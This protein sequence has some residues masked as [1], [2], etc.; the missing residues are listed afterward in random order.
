VEH[1]SPELVKSVG[2]LPVV[3]ICLLIIFGQFIAMVMFLRELRRDIKE[4]TRMIT[5][6]VSAQTRRVPR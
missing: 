4:L 1:V 3:T 2:D 5:E 6:L